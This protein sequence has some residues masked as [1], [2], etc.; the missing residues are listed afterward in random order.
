MTLGRYVQNT[1]PPKLEL[2]AGTCRCAGVP[3]RFVL[4]GHIATFDL[5]VLSFF[6]GVSS[7]FIDTLRQHHTSCLVIPTGWEE[8]FEKECVTALSH[9]LDDGEAAPTARIFTERVINWEVSQENWSILLDEG[10]VVAQRAALHRHLVLVPGDKGG[11]AAICAVKYALDCMTHIGLPYLP[12]TKLSR[13]LD[14]ASEVPDG[15]LYNVLDEPREM[16]LAFIA[17]SLKGTLLAKFIG[18]VEDFP[19]LYLLPK[20]VDHSRV[21][22]LR[23]RGIGGRSPS[24][25]TSWGKR[26]F[27]LLRGVL[28]LFSDTSLSLFKESG[29]KYDFNVPSI[30]MFSQGICGRPFSQFVAYDIVSMYDNIRHSVATR[31]VG[32]LLEWVRG[33]LGKP[34]DEC[35]TLIYQKDRP[36][37]EWARPGDKAFSVKELCDTLWVVLRLDGWQEWGSQ[38]LVPAHIVRMGAEWA[39]P[40]A[41]AVCS[42]MEIRALEACSPPERRLLSCCTFRYLDNTISTQPAWFDLVSYTGMENKP[43]KLL[44]D[45]SVEFLDCK[46]YDHNGVFAL[47]LRK[48]PRAKKAFFSLIPPGGR[49][50]VLYTHLTRISRLTSHV[51]MQGEECLKLANSLRGQDFPEDY[52][53]SNFFKFFTTKHLRI[54]YA[55]YEWLLKRAP[56]VESFLVKRIGGWAEIWRGESPNRGLCGTVPTTIF[57]YCEGVVRRHHNEAGVARVIAGALDP[58]PSMNHWILPKSFWEAVSQRIGASWAIQFHPFV[59]AL[60]ISHFSLFLPATPF[61]QSARESFAAGNLSGVLLVAPQGLTPHGGMSNIIPDLKSGVSR[62]VRGCSLVAVVSSLEAAPQGLEK[63]DLVGTLVL[64]SC[65]LVQLMRGWDR[66]QK[67]APLA[68]VFGVYLWSSPQVLIRIH[69]QRRVALEGLLSHIHPS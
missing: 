67:N 58:P 46:I 13:R 66:R 60:K 65:T 37:L 7:D 1:F 6:D 11:M 17:K 59:R 34:D 63:A 29:V 51:W 25:S 21:P 16:A 8:I 49:R 64:D 44:P 30:Y 23:Y 3:Q 40:L 33:K 43:E 47:C 62:Q 48:D 69:N 5:T 42:M 9:W 56:R 54:P 39:P 4:D 52:L 10:E 31:E 38:I 2:P 27:K 15:P 41:C 32:C 53:R 24:Y 14:K 22:P 20:A 28:N 50:A 35:L 68:R 18:P 19:Y 55:L 36:L 45:N 26:M 61:G 12:G 57:K